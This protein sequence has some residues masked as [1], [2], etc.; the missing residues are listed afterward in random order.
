LKEI[1]GMTRSLLTSVI[2]VCL[3]ALGA[4]SGSNPETA[5]QQYLANGNK[6]LAEGKAREAVVEYRNALRHD[7]LFGEARRKLAE[8]L[9]KTGNGQAAFREMIRAADLLPEDS[10]VQLA[11]GHYLLLAQRYEDAK[12]RAEGVLK[13]EPRNVE[14]LVMRANAMA[15]LKD[16]DGAISEIEEAVRLGENDE[17]IFTNLA[18][19]RSM[20]GRRDEAEVAFKSALVADPKSINA[21]LAAAQFYLADRRVSEA[22][23]LLNDAVAIEPTHS[24]A[25][26]M[27][28]TLYM[29]TKRAAEAEQPLNRAVQPENLDSQLALAD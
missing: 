27:L 11:A 13:R 9:A 3:A 4:A 24:L 12:T 14:A 8:A 15:G 21:R 1:L 7:P 26:R 28:A 10:E 25:N 18:V 29:L 16:V 20:G 17:R 19:L 5:K 2:I 23:K 22:E 6:F